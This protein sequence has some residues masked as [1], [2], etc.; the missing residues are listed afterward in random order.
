ML[1]YLAASGIF[2]TRLRRPL[3]HFTVKEQQYEGAFR[4]VTSR[5]IACKTLEH[6]LYLQ[7]VY[8]LRQQL[9]CVRP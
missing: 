7:L 5:V 8:I 6:V 9:M 1:A 2:L 3:G 4:H